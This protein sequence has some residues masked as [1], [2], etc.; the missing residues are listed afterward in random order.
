MSEIRGGRGDVVIAQWWNSCL[1]CKK[2][3]IQFLVLLIQKNVQ[4][5]GDGRY[6]NGSNTNE[7]E[8]SKTYNVSKYWLVQIVILGI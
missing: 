2:Y 6:L 7:E 1:A 8:Q 4:L 5:A 3:L